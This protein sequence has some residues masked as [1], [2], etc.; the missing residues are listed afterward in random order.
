VVDHDLLLVGAVLD[1]RES[2]ATVA[3]WLLA[4]EVTGPLIFTFRLGKCTGKC[5]GNSPKLRHGWVGSRQL[6]RGIKYW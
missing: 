2:K 4:V 5:L 3:I 1:L 6:S